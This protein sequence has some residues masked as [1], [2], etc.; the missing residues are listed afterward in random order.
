MLRELKIDC[1]LT[2][3][4][5]VQAA[6]FIVFSSTPMIFVYTR[7]QFFMRILGGTRAA[8]SGAGYLWVKSLQ[9]NWE[10][11][12]FSPVLLENLVGNNFTCCASKCAS[13]GSL[14][15]CVNENLMQD[16]SYWISRKIELT[17]D[18]P[19]PTQKGIYRRRSQ[20]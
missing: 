2:S 18:S 8:T 4:N 20:A 6:R 19:G 5:L 10:L 7:R 3:T 12:G 14:K 17:K 11:G 15:T 9:A 13:S 16:Y 1:N